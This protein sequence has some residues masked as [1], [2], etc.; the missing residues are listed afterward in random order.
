MKQRY[1]ITAAL[2]YANGPLHFGHLAGVYI[3]SDIYARHRRLQGHTVKFIS[4]S[5]EHGVGVMVPAEKEKMPYQEFV[6]KWNAA[7][8]RL[9]DSLDVQFDFFGR[10][11]AKYHEAET[12]DWFTDLYKKGLIDIRTEKQ[13]YCIDDGKFLPDRF[14][15]GTC[16]ACGY[17]QARGDESPNL[18]ELI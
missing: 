14:V 11:T 12:L 8:I 18:R 5:D 13:L 1:L 4:G 16:Y 7:H 2:P 6:D 10:T 17:A 3:P 9:F 15:E